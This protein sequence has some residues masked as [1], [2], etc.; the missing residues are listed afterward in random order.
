MRRVLL[1]AVTL[2]LFARPGLAEDKAAVDQATSAA[3]AWLA[4]T[5]TAKYG[6]SWEEAAPY[7]RAAISKADWESALHASRA[8]LGSLKSRRLRS[9]TFTRTAPGAPDAEYVVVEF[10]TQFEH[11]ATAVET[12]TPM[13]DKD[14]SWRVSGYYIK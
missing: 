13:R 1:A 4:L 6:Q 5:D 8:P 10:D 7:F 3:T 2:L 14:G 9:A 11:K 12:V